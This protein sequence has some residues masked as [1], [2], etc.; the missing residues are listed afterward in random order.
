MMCERSLLGD[1]SY[2][3]ASLDFSGAF[4]TVVRESAL[5]RLKESG[6]STST[7]S[8]LISNTTARIKLHHQLSGRFATNLGVVQGVPL[9]PL[10]FITYTEK[11]M[12]A[13]DDAVSAPHGLPSQFTQYAD[14]TMVHDKD[15]DSASQTVLSCE[16]IFINDNLKLNVQKTQ[17]FTASKTDNSWKSVKLLGSHL[18]S[19]ED[20]SARMNPANRAFGTVSWK[21]H[22]L[23]SRLA[24]FSTLILPVLL[25]NCGLWTLSKTLTSKL[26]TWHQRK[27]RIVLGIFNPHRISNKRLYQQTKQRPLSEICRQRRLLRFGHIARQ[28]PD[29]TSRKALEMAMNSRDIKKPRGRPLLRWI[30]IV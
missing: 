8:T 21:R 17:Y 23:K 14:D 1:W 25:Y 30:D 19:V 13:I 26:D 29:S 22:T 24:M 15:P 12:R 5:E 3:G 16:P 11:T 20:V 7:V 10:M 2:S 18:G 27:L 9:S 6:A 28:H 4:D